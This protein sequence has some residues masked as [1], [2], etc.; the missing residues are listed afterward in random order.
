MSQAVNSNSQKFVE[1]GEKALEQVGNSLGALASRFSFVGAAAKFSLGVAIT[2]AT[3]PEKLA[4]ETL[5]IITDTANTLTAKASYFVTKGLEVDK[6]A[7]TALKDEVV[8]E[9]QTH[10]KL[11]KQGLIN[12]ALTLQE[13]DDIRINGK[14]ITGCIAAIERSNLTTQDKDQIRGLYVDSLTKLREESKEQIDRLN[15]SNLKA[16]EYAVKRGQVQEEF[17]ASL[18]KLTGDTREVVGATS[19]TIYKQQRRATDKE[20]LPDHKSQ[21]ARAWNEARRATTFDKPSFFRGA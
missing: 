12:A 17:G 9:I 6:K 7:R 20:A 18:L 21:I 5:D 19:S 8:G 15:S 1:T 4:D 10:V 16:H 3:K 14:A 11:V 2:A 13:S